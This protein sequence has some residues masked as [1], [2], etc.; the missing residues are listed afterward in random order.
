MVPEAAQVIRD[1]SGSEVLAAEQYIDM[2]SGRTFRQTLLVHEAIKSA[3][4]RSL[5]PARIAGLHIVA[6]HRA[7]GSPA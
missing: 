2:M 5:D 4:D 3:I 1:L 6:A 7:G